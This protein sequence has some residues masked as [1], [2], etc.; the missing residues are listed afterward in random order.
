MRKIY[1]DYE[2]MHGHVHDLLRKINADWFKPVYV[3]GLTRGGLLPAILISQYLNIPMHTLKVSLR[4]GEECESNA[5]MSEDAYGHIEY[6]PMATGDGRKN[7]LIVDDI[8]DTGATLKWIVDDWQ[9]SCMPHDDRWD[10]VWHHN[11]KFAV[12]V[13]N[14]ASEQKVNYS[15]MEINKAED[16]SWIVFPVEDWWHNKK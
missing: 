6:D 8:N 13:D 2:Q 16:P 5:W 7:I 11:V 12:I 4:D 14:L 10:N 15:S 3:F 9:S 1:I